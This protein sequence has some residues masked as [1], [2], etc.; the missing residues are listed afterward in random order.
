M[1]WN[2]PD[3]KAFFIN[4]IAFFFRKIIIKKII[5]DFNA[6]A[7]TQSEAIYRW[8]KDRQIVIASGMKMSQFDLVSAPVSNYTISF[9]HGIAWKK[10]NYMPLQPILILINRQSFNDI[11]TIPPSSPYG[12]FSD[13]SI[14]TLH[15]TCCLIMGLVL[16]Q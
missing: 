11:G 16:A 4:S 6:V 13:S 10:K 2:Q 8:N 5:V 9:K 3:R 15:S 12:E 7:Y 1:L 14:R